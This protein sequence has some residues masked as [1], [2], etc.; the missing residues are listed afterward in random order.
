M[1]STAAPMFDPE[2]ETYYPVLQQGAGL[3]NINDA[4][5]AK[6]VIMMGE[7]DFTLGSVTGSAADG[8][9]KAELGDYI[10]DSDPAG[11]RQ[12]SFTIYNI[13]DQDQEIHLDT[14]LFIQGWYGPDDYE[15]NQ[16]SLQTIDVEWDVQY[17]YDKPEGDG[18]DVNKDGKTNKDDAQAIL[19]VLTGILDASLIDRAAADMDGDGDIT[20]YDSYLLLTYVQSIP[21]VLIVPAGES[22]EVVVTITPD[23]D[24]VAFLTQEGMFP[25]GF[26]IEGFTYA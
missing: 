12:F 8:K 15:N 21:E 16:M 19:D 22:R 11:S 5:N 13:D 23:E 18:H 7:E 24:N 2:Y 4:L 20:S 3:V 1:M 26:Y 6:S 17:D 10:F 9:V 25:N 14:D